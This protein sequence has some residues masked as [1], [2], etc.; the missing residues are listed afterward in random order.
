MQKLGEFKLPNFFNYP[1]Y[2]TLQPVRD[3]REKQIQLWKEL[4]IDYCKT[5]KIFVI[6]IE[7]EFPLFTNTV[8]EN[9]DS[10]RSLTHEAREALLSALVSEG[11]AEWMDKGRRKCLILWHRIQD[12]ADILLQFREHDN[13]STG[14]KDDAFRIAYCGR[15]LLLL[16]WSNTWLEI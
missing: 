14:R 6:G 3:T 2:F 7:D 9:F 1:P 10:A 12:W 8:I 11:R 5:Q 16:L 15:Y 4:I 13:W